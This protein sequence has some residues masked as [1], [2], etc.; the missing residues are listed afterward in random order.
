MKNT[1]TRFAIMAGLASGMLF[2]QTP[3][4]SNSAQPPAEHRQSNRGQFFDRMATRLS[5]TEDQKQQ[6]RSI[7]QAARESSKPVAQQLRQSRQALRD[8]VKAG[9]SGAEID[10]L[11]ANVG[12]VA[13][14]LATIRAKSFA[15]TY[16]LLTPEQR[17]KADEMAH[18]ARGTFRGGH[19]HRDGAGA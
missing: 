4:P 5:L 12:N 3:A 19:G 15:K 2:A 7:M 14:Q 17:T 10:Q 11:S 1:F 13:G 9:K 8:A 18:H 6:T 16:A